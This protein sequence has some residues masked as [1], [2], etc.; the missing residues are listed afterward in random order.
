MP[1]QTEMGH[2]VSDRDASRLWGTP[3]WLPSGPKRSTISLAFK[4]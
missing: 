2:H 4:I 1:E 3:G